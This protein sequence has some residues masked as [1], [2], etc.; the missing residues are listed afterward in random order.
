MRS[1]WKKEKETRKE[2]ERK[3]TQS[4]KYRD[5]DTGRDRRQ[6]GRDGQTPRK[7]EQETGAGDPESAL[8][9]RGGEGSRAGEGRL[10]TGWPCGVTRSLAPPPPQ[11]S[12]GAG[13][14]R[15]HMADEK[16]GGQP[17]ED[18]APQDVSVGDLDPTWGIQ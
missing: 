2:A 15:G 1:K 12:T 4:K 7:P 17:E 13:L 8:M 11:D 16:A 14:P 6:R 9:G 5:R 3:R 10:E 18:E